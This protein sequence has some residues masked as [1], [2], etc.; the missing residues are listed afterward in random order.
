[1]KIK[2]TRTSVVEYS[3]GDQDLA[4]YLEQD[5]L[6]IDQIAFKDLADL[7][8]GMVAIDDI[9]GGGVEHTYEVFLIDD[10]LTETA[11]DA[12]NTERDL[13]LFPLDEEDDED[14]EDEEDEED[15][16][17]KPVAGDLNACGE[18][19]GRVI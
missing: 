17:E 1:M 16:D 18:A 9:D 2:I 10:D 14:E 15:D 13:E 7:E 3:A 4:Y 12:T 11:P 8:E 5:A 19:Y 6:N